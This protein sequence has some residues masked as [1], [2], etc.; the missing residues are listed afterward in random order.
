MVEEAFKAQ[1][2]AM[3]QGGDSRD[4]RF[5]GSISM[6]WVLGLSLD[7][8]ALDSIVVNLSYGVL[9]AMIAVVWNAASIKWVSMVG[10]DL[11]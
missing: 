10:I 9:G 2:L 6:T 5:L 3:T 11:G 7:Q 4:C 1:I 8:P